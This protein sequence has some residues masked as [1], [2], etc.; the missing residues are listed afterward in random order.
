MA[1]SP[2]PVLL[3]P[4]APPRRHLGG[5]RSLLRRA[6]NWIILLALL[7]LAGWGAW[8]GYAALAATPQAQVPVAQV[9][10]GDVQFTVEASGTL[11]GGHSQSLTA[12]MVS[13]DTLS[14]RSLLPAGTLVQPGEVVIQFDTTAQQY[15][16]T[17]AQEALAQA[18]QQ[19]IAAQA[20]AAAQTVDDAYQLSKA[21]F[22]VQR[23]QLQVRANPIKAA[24]DAKKNDLA[25]AAA[26]EHLRQLQQDIASRAAN[27]Q[28]SV[29]VQ[30]AAEAKAAADAATARGN[31][32]AM[33]LRASQ[34]G[35]VSVE[36][37]TRGGF[38]GNAFPLYQTGD[39]TDPGL[40]IAEIPDTT[41]WQL[42]VDI[43]ELDR[44]H[45]AVGQVATAEFPALPGRTFQ[46][47]IASIAGATGP[48]WQRQ[49]KVNLSLRQSA[50]GL[51]PGMSAQVHIQTQTLKNVLY[52]PSQAVFGGAAA[53][54]VY[55][56][57]RG[58]FQRHPVKVQGRSASQVV[59]TG[60]VEGD[61]IALANPEQSS[62]P[63]PAPTSAPGRGPALPR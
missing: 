32:A 39:V 14:I 26:Q 61:A 58:Q 19:V 48:P 50:P 42:Q 3:P 46:A 55:L 33:T 54:F 25:L 43:N 35:Y 2:Q 16:L 49:V 37:N 4:P 62:V 45:L 52:V 5:Q 7:A 11:S 24:V 20:T 21:R 18:Q 1:A 8:R 22:D 38:D 23:A 12:P 59:L 56:Q 13:G 6:L 29:A 9:R 10:R 57:S 30:L 31:I 47:S 34:A 17:Q 60:V 41:S 53:P 28:A 44:G 40:A 51:K 15:N 36:S 27:N 63:A